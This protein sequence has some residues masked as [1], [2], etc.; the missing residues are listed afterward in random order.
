MIKEVIYGLGGFDPNKENDNIIKVIH[1]SETELTQIEAV[2]AREI[3]RQQLL[4]KLG[5]TEEEARLLL[6]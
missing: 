4:E 3:Q 2:K 6:G 5:I 1:Y